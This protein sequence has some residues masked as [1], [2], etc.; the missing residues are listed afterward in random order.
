MNNS[1]TFFSIL[2]II[3]GLKYFKRQ[4]CEIRKA[5]DISKNGIQLYAINYLHL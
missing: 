3:L 4:D 2:L 5:F 1:Y